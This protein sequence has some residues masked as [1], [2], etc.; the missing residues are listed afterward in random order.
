[1]NFF[2]REATIDDASLLFSWVNDKYVRLN[3][4]NQ[5][6]IKWENHLKWLSNKL[7]SKETHIY[8]LADV[9][10]NYGQ[11]RIDRVDDCW[12]ID[13]SIDVNNR[14]RG[15]GSLIVKLL[16]EKF[17]KYKF[18]AIVKKSNLSSIR[19]FNKLGFNE[20]NGELKNMIYFEKSQINEE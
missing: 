19:V 15:L 12:V 16:I 3:S 9:S 17:I 11:I 7:K 18:K 10:T 5:E 20:V 8:I 6:T 14:G 2:L 1:M 13:Y 4:I